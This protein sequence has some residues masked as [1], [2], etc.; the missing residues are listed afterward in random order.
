MWVDS[1]RSKDLRLFRG[2]ID[3][4]ARGIDAVTRADR[5]QRGYSG[6]ESAFDHGR[7]IGIKVRCNDYVREDFRNHASQRQWH[8]AVDDDDA[9]KGGLAIRFK[10]LLPGFAQIFIGAADTTRIGVLENGQGGAAEFVDEAAGGID[11]QDVRVGEVFA[12]EL[13][14][15]I[16]EV[17][18]Y[19]SNSI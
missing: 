5:Y 1:D 14:E 16:I 13:H 3:R 7:S 12:V 11:V 8:G 17:N 2:E 19:S 6:S 4:R 10:G 15:V 9:A 18:G